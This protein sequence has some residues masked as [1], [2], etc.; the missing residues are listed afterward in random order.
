MS[1]GLPDNWTSG[2]LG[3]AVEIVRGIS[4]PSGDKKFEPEDGLIACLRT[5][6]VQRD[7]EWANL[8]YVPERH[9]RRREQEVRVGDI[10]ISTANSLE[11]VGKVAPVRHVPHRATLGAFISLLR[12]SGLLSPEF[13][14]YQ[15]AAA[16]Y[17]T[18]IRSTA[19]TT[20]NISNVSTEKLRFLPFRLAPIGEQDRIVAEIE[21]QF[22]RLDAAVAALR[23]VQANLKRYRAA[24]LKAACEGR[25]VLTEAELASKESRSYETGE[26]LLG[27][28]LKERR[29]K[30]EADQLARLH[31]SGKPPQNDEWRKSYREPKPQAMDN[32]PKLPE[33]WAWA[34]V[35][36]LSWYVRNGISTKPDDSAGL[37]ILRISAV[38]PMKVDLQDVRFLKDKPE[39][40]EYELDSGDLLFTRY[41]GTREFVG[42]CG[43]VP[44]GIGVLVHPDKLIRVRPVLNHALGAYI[45]IAANT[46]HSRAFVERKIRT[47]AGQ[48]GVSGEDVRGIPIPLCPLSEQARI[49]AEV[50][51]RLSSVDAAQLATESDMARAD[52]LRQSILKRAFEGKLVPQDPDDEPASMLLER[53]RA[54]HENRR[55]PLPHR[56]SRGV[57]Q[58]T[59]P[60]EV[61]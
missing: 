25:I 19:S 28:I 51:A 53:I 30:W 47:T 56:R 49:V 41:N 57:A 11:L 61:E 26:Q 5:T 52:R 59:V 1:N 10:L 21:K 22:T 42:V 45:A 32:K 14:Y 23:R 7:V 33:G 6:N 39:Y 29:T 54:E 17:Q 8:W 58:R 37:A 4:F 38:K 31:S 12:P 2:T 60:V 40:H 15:I 36:Q 43:L 20:T 44:T 18:A 46:G 16:E 50:D 27:R 48:S 3:D 24:V 34:S 55:D 9:M 13:V 35:D